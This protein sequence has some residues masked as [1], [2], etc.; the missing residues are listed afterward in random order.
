MDSQTLV[1]I[2]GWVLFVMAA[3][4]CTHKIGISNSVFSR[5]LV[6]FVGSGILLTIFFGLERGFV[7][8]LLGPPLLFAYARISKASGRNAVIV[9]KAASPAPQTALEVLAQ[10]DVWKTFP[11]SF[12]EALAAKLKTSTKATEFALFCERTGVLISNI[13][14]YDL[15]EP[16]LDIG[17]AAITVTSYGYKMAQA[18][19]YSE[20]RE[21]WELALLLGPQHVPAW[22]GMAIL[23]AN[24]QDCQ[25]ATYW[26]DKVLNYCP[27][28]SSDDPI[29]V[30][31]AQ[32][33][34]GEAVELEREAA[35]AFN[36]SRI[37]GS[38]NKVRN[39][40]REIKAMCSDQSQKSHFSTDAQQNGQPTGPASG[41]PTS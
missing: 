5:K 36:D 6:L 17:K 4:F 27:N 39:Q 10:R 41:E 11:S 34:A 21:A 14:G 32:L 1:H 35:A 40:M 37:I 29:E 24:E 13:A 25:S 28:L 15:H 22:I 26:A 33:M 23:S 19:R 9:L 8:F 31:N 12:L 7:Y 2:T 20:A 38:T 3:S 18:N 16:E 30:V